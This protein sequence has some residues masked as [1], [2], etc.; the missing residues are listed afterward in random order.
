[1]TSYNPE[2]TPADQPTDEPGESIS[3]GL[4]DVTV[5]ESGRVVITN[6]KLAEVI[7]EEKR[8]GGAPAFFLDTKCGDRNCGDTNCGDGDDGDDGGDE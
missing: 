2:E 1:M 3:I 4:G 5:D 8:K 7:A 6:A